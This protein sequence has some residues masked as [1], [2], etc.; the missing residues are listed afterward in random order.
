LCIVVNMTCRISRFQDGGSFKLN[1]LVT[2]WTPEKKRLILYYLSGSHGICWQYTQY[3]VYFIQIYHVW[4]GYL[5]KIP[6]QRRNTQIK[7]PRFNKIRLQGR[8]FNYFC[9][10]LLIWH[11]EFHVFKMVD[12]SS[13]LFF[14]FFPPFFL[15][16]LKNH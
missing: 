16:I 3:V 11:V 10:L 9:V 8:H 5:R 12:P 4:E 7:I 1:P 13:Y 2:T 6:V 14:F 15:L